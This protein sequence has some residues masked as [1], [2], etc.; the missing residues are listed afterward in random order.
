MNISKRYCFA[1]SSAVLLA[2]SAFSGM[3]AR[4]Q[5]TRASLIALVTQVQKADY[6][7]NR[8]ALQRLY[9][10]FA[11]FI[12]D[13]KLASR[14]YYWRGFA[15]WRRAINGFNESADPKDL[16]KDLTQ[17]IADFKQSAEKDAGFVDAKAGT[18]ACLSNLI[19]LNMGNQER[20][21][22]LIAQSS[23][24]VKEAKAADADHPRLLWALGPIYW[25]IPV[26]RG[27]GQEKSIAV[28]QQGLDSIR[29]R[30][31]AA[32]VT[33]DALEP[34]WGEPELLMSAAWANLNKF[35]PDVNAAEQNARAALQIVPYWHYVRDIL[36][37]QIEK[38]KASAKP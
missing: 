34:S 10:D 19:Y 5:Q 4:A 7:G 29:K 14:A 23:Q 3:P 16:E 1:A 24:L 15:L 21:Q 33:A 37:P 12:A 30:K 8:P 18:I 27:G 28:N 31:A 26:E 20:V 13:D 38:A 32:G 11:P 25:N 36:I 35:V 2:I 17:A 6:E 22:E 9:A